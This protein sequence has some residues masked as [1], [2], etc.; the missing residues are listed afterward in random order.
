MLALLLLAGIGALIWRDGGDQARPALWR[1]SQGE[2]HAWL[3]GTIHAVP[4]GANWLT[5]A[6]EKAI[7]ESDGL[8]LEA[9]GLEAERNSRAVFERLGR[10]PGLPP[11]AQRLSAKDR[12]R[13]AELPV[14][15]LDAYESWAAALLIAAAANGEA[16]ASGEAAPE[17][18]LEKKLG[19]RVGATQGLETIEEQLG[20]F[21][22]LSGPDQG[23]L[24]ARAIDEARH[25]PRLFAQL[26]GLWARGDLTALEA[27][28]LGPLARYPRLRLALIDRRNALWARRIDSLL[29]KNGKTLFIAV[30]TGHL[31]GPESVIVRL[32]RLGWRVE[33]VQ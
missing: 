17:A 26:Y 7:G 4:K 25:A 13:L 18:V 33:R 11:V 8:V 12:A 9:S 10:S 6:L 32:G 28:A 27:Q 22:R 16:G 14:G 23:V 2:R 31:V 19:A 3:F 5:P 20:L 21:D 15:N 1:I 24:L 29:R 30:G